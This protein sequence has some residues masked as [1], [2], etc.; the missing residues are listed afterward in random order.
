MDTCKNCGTLIADLYC[1]HCGQE[2]ITG[3]ITVKHIFK[4]V[5]HGFFHWESSI[6]STIKGLIIRPGRLIRS[7]ID[8]QRKSFVKP[9]TYFI[10]I[11][12]IYVLIFHWLGDKYFA[13]M[14][15]TIKT[16]GDV[17]ESMVSKIHDIQY[18]INQN[19][20]YFNYVMPL[21][22]AFYVRLFLKKTGGINYAESLVFSL[23]A[24]G[25]TLFFGIFFML[26]SLINYDIWNVR[27]L[28]NLFY[29]IFAITQF[30][31]LPLFRGIIRGF[32]ASFLSYLTYII[33][34]TIVT[35]SYLQIVKGVKFF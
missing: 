31:G 28:F 29:M 27:L 20:N 23:Y 12:T 25:T 5:T 1:P 13:F 32:F 17:T 18:L 7:Y 15:A 22:F 10:F 34:I 33:I 11:Q 24:A 26:L 2:K 21:I 3:R 19:I 8:G 4:D 9:F 35:L 30:S 16:G 14:N 6:F